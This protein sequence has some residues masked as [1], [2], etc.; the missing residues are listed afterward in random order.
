LTQARANQT[1]AEKNLARVQTLFTRGIAARREVEDAQTQLTLA[2][3]AATQAQ[4]ALEAARVNAMHGVGEAQTQATV[5][6][7]GVA[8]AQ[9][10]LQVSRAE[11]ARA[12]I[13]APISGTVTKRS[14]NDGETVDP[15]TPAFEIIDSSSLDLLANLPAQY[16]DRI[17][18]GNLALVKVE[19]F[20]DKEFSGSVV[21]VA[22]S[23]DAQTNTVTVRVRLPNPGGEL[24]SG[25]YGSTR[26]AVEIHN[27]A[28]TVPEAALVVEGDETFV[29]VTKSDEEVEKRKVEAGIRSEGRVEI[30][31]GLKENERVVTKGAFGLSD[32]AKIKIGEPAKEES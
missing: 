13:Q 28:L 25:L 11:L 8:A 18:T 1:Q 5:A 27:D 2:S 22:P 20:P 3:G 30:V 24:K 12:A 29:F 17:K 16:L 6:A 21:S 15:A 10:A 19:P 31:D 26:I 32:G 4:S 9:A 23:V 14:I 7:G